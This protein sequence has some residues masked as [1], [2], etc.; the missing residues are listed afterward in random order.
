VPH[1]VR[2][3]VSFIVENLIVPRTWR[4][5]RARIR[6]AGELLR[7]IDA[8]MGPKPSKT[9]KWLARERQQEL[10]SS[11]W[12]TIE[13][14]ILTPGHIENAAIDGARDVAR[15]TIAVLRFFQRRLVPYFSLEI[16]T[17]G[18]GADIGGVIESRWVTDRTGKYAAGGWQQHG[19]AGSWTFTPAHLRTYRA[20]PRFVYLDAALRARNPD[21]WQGRFLTT[22]RTMNIA[23]IRERPSIRIMLFATALEAL[24]GDT[25][26]AGGRDRRQGWEPNCDLV[27]SER[28]DAGRH[29]RATRWRGVRGSWLLERNAR[30]ATGEGHA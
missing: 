23:T 15:D 2:R 4:V 13:V 17:F 6:P 1:V 29:G 22:L 9:Q 20:D 12:A 19:I 24:L 30:C 8:R 26:Q 14:P 21:D 16:Q 10:G 11:K 28:A 25:F 7:R 5:G 3:E 18:L 27:C